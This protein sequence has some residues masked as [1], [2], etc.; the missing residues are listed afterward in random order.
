MSENQTNK[1]KTRYTLNIILKI[2]SKHYDV[3]VGNKSI[4]KHGEFSV[5]EHLNDTLNLFINN[6]NIFISNEIKRKRRRRILKKNTNCNLKIILKTVVDHESGIMDIPLF[7]KTEICIYDNI[8]STLNSFAKD[9]KRFIE[10]KLIQMEKI[11]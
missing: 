5:I 3:G 7:K 10:N 11:K 9:M 4:F 2:I 6:L 8:N 1:K